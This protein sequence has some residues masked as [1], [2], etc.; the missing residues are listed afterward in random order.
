[1]TPRAATASC[2]ARSTVRSF[3]A[4]AAVEPLAVASLP[5]PCS[6]VCKISLPWH[7]VS[8]S[9]PY[10]T[11]GGGCASAAHTTT[12]AEGAGAETLERAV[13][14]D[15]LEQLGDELAGTGTL[16]DAHEVSGAAFIRLAETGHDDVACQASVAQHRDCCVSEKRAGRLVV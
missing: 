13:A 14:S 4:A 15:G 12:P 2:T 1:M 7:V 8:P 10:V 16:L 3:G 11:N 9:L 6:F 5:L